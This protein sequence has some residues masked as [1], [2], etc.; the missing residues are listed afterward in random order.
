MKKA[1]MTT[2]YHLCSTDTNPRHENCP[3]GT[4]SWC[5]W[6]KAKAAGNE[7]HFNHSPPLHPDVQKHLW[8]IYEDLTN[9]DLLQRCLGGHTQNSNESYNSTVWR[10]APKHLN[11]G[12]KNIEIAAFIAA[13]VFNKG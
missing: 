4:E 7:T 8:P 11:S 6:Q 1:I 9:D 13:G 5:E 2:L 12:R 10:L 3:T